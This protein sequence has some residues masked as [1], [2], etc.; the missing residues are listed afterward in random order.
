MEKKRKRGWERRRR[1]SSSHTGT[2]AETFEKPILRSDLNRARGGCSEPSSEVFVL[3][4]VRQSSGALWS[5]QYYPCAPSHR[6]TMAQQELQIQHRAA[7]PSPAAS[8]P[9][10]AV[11]K[12][13]RQIL[14]KLYSGEKLGLAD[15]NRSVHSTCCLLSK[16]LC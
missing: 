1:A 12:W 6:C 14:P 2:N 3:W 5:W 16:F 10:R 15:Q 13:T 8:D 7:T 11:H 4:N 9:F